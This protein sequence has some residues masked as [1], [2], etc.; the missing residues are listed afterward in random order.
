MQF[1]RRITHILSLFLFDDRQ[2][3]ISKCM[4][5]KPQQ[6]LQAHYSPLVRPKQ[7]I[8]PRANHRDSSDSPLVMPSS[9]T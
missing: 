2:A 3:L 5:Q 8:A 4:Y 9:P 7:E 6:F 1:M